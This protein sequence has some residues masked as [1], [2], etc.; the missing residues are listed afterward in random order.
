MVKKSSLIVLA[1]LLLSIVFISNCSDDDKKETLIGTWVLTSM[2][3]SASGITVT[4]DPAEIGLSQ[5]LTVYDDN[6]YRMVITE[7][8][9]TTTS[10]G[11]W[12]TSG[13]KLYTTEEGETEVF[14]YSLKG[15]K[16]EIVYEETEEGQTVTITQ[17]FTRQ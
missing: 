9:E 12:S 16:L 8:G 7:E 2:K 3:M 17:I 6:T 10:Y 11:E 4:V 1:I 14:D 5:T 15:D 13:G